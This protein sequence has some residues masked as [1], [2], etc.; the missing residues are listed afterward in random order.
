M[1]LNLGLQ[2]KF[3]VKIRYRFASFIFNI[4]RRSAFDSADVKFLAEKQRRRRGTFVHIYFD[5]AVS[6]RRRFACLCRF[7]FLQILFREK[8][9]ISERFYKIF[10]ANVADF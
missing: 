1:I 4:F 2:Q 8:L 7:Y 6:G 10:G 5:R 9:K 3:Y